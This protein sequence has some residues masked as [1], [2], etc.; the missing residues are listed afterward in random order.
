[1]E[2]PVPHLVLDTQILYRAGLGLE[3]PDFRKLLQLSETGQIKISIPFIVWEERRTQLFEIACSKFKKL[4]EAFDGV[5]NHLLSNIALQGL[6]PPV[7]N[8]RTTDEL[9]SQTT[10][11]MR[12]LAE[13]YKI[14]IR[15]LGDD[16][17]QR[18]W[19]RYF[20]AALPFNKNEPRENR[21]KDIP[22]AWI[23][24]SILDIRAQHPELIALCDDDKMSSALDSAGIPVIKGIVE[25]LEK[26]EEDPPLP[27]E[28][29]A[30]PQAAPAEGGN[31]LEALLAQADMQFRSS[32]A[33]VL[34]YVGYLRDPSKIQLAR[35]LVRSG[36]NIDLIENITRRLVFANLIREVGD[37]FL[38]KDM[39]AC[40]LAAEQVEEE[41]IE[42]LKVGEE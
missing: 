3:N 36:M 5:Q 17:A 30:A 31:A 16:H 42:F 37:Q 4:E 2:K 8:S 29:E 23:F 41:I 7:L 11:A 10:E 39:R 15:P 38:P 13:K 18:A 33:K 9:E 12:S 6:L 40:A 22:D 25:F 26:F 28:A 32:E 34:G 14:D 24:E 21:R 35:L 20:A 27:V 1:M 19:K